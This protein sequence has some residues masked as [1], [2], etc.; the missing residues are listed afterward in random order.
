MMTLICSV[1][2]LLRILF[3]MFAFSYRLQ[4]IIEYLVEFLLEPLVHEWFSDKERDTVVTL[5]IIT[6]CIYVYL[7]RFY[8]AAALGAPAI[9]T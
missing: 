7:G 6:S 8:R 5:T 4:I 9:P 3:L 2:I 1:R